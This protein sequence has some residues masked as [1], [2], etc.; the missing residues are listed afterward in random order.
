VAAA[1]PQYL[2]VH[3]ERLRTSVE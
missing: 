1:V 3:H 2:C